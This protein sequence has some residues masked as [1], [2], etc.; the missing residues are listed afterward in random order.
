MRLHSDHRDPHQTIS[1]SDVSQFLNHVHSSSGLPWWAS[2][3]IATLAIRTALLPLSLRA[4]VMRVHIL[5]ALDPSSCPS[6]ISSLEFENS[7]FK[8]SSANLI[9]INEALAKARLLRG[10]LMRMEGGAAKAPS[11]V[12]PKE[13]PLMNHQHKAPAPAPA[14]SVTSSELKP[15]G[16]SR[17]PPGM[18]MWSLSRGIYLYN[19][20]EHRLP[21][22]KWFFLNG[23]VQVC[24]CTKM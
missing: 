7:T 6:F 19:Q 3:P 14:S 15:Q 11:S 22:L 17:L 2:I 23:I 21:S 5:N 12:N 13:A 10:G 20:A 16:R 24:A 9:L 4:K 1:Y 8:A 18:G